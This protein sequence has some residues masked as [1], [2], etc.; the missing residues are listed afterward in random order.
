MEFL[1]FPVVHDLLT[2]VREGDP[3]HQGAVELVGQNDFLDIFR[4]VFGAFLFLP[5]AGDFL[6]EGLR[7]LER[8]LVHLM[9]LGADR[10]VSVFPLVFSNHFNVMLDLVNF[11]V[12]FA[13]LHFNLILIIQFILI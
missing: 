7:G 12:V 2:L 6:L 10:R 13:A 5:Q 1:E 8:R 4:I 3:K 11:F 9:E